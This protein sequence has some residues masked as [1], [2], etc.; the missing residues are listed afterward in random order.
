MNKK[1]DVIIEQL[2]LKKKTKD[3]NKPIVYKRKLRI[4]KGYPLISIPKELLNKL[5]KIMNAEIYVEMEGNFF[6]REIIIKFPSSSQQLVKR[7][8]NS[9]TQNKPSD[10]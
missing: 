4:V 7:K 10:V 2:N 5:V 8:G 3:R 1:T 9:K 6:E